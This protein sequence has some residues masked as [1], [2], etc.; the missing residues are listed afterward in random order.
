MPRIKLQEKS[1]LFEDDKPKP[2]TRI[3]DMPD[4]VAHAEHKAPKDRGLKDYYHFCY[5]QVSAYNRAWNYF[6]GM[7]D[8]DV[9]DYIY[10]GT[11]WDRP[12]WKFAHSGSVDEILKKKAW[13][14][15]HFTD[16]EP[17]RDKTAHGQREQTQHTQMNRNSPEHQAL[18]VLGLM[19]P[20]TLDDIKSEYKKLV[21]KYHPD[22]NNNCP[23]AEEKSKNINAA[24]TV[25]RLAYQKY[26][27]IEKKFQG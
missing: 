6:D 12:T 15:Y 2:Q 13:Q 21:K 22:L 24:Y 20:V 7:P 4:C 10:K 19:P 26:E 16:K 23:M 3:C 8:R 1:P 5:D 18:E 9:E 14:A 27:K 17:P 25:L 11:I